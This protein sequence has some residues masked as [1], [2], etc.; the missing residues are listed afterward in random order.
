MSAKNFF[1]AF[2]PSKPI[3]TTQRGT[4][5]E[6]L[7]QIPGVRWATYMGEGTYEIDV[8]DGYNAADVQAVIDQMMRDGL[9]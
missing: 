7:Q 6:R 8:E 3:V 9:L 1:K 2:L 5:Y 4:N